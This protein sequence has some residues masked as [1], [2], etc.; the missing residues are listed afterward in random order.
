LLFFKLAKSTIIK[1]TRFSWRTFLSNKLLHIT[2]THTH[3]YIYLFITYVCVCFNVILISSGHFSSSFTTKI[4]THISFTSYVLHTWNNML[5][6]IVK[7]EKY[8]E[9]YK[10]QSIS[11]FKLGPSIFYLIPPSQTWIFSWIILQNLHILFTRKLEFSEQMFLSQ[12]IYEI[13]KTN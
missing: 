10:S 3:I 8:C 2:H 5:I 13:Q 9:Q 4:Y 12:D 6:F 1:F 11:S 7:S